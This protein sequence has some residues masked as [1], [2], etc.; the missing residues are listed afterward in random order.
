MEVVKIKID[1]LKPYA[2]NVKLHPKDQIEQIKQSIKEFGNNDP[3]AVDEDNVIIEGHG[4]YM[5]LLELGYEEVEI[6]RLCGMTEDKKNA[7]RL[8]HNKLTMN[9]GFDIDALER[10][11]ESIQMDLAKYDLEI[12]KNDE[13]IVNEIEEGEIPEAPIE[14]KTKKG[15]RFLL[16]DHELMC[17]DS[18]NAEDVAKLM[19][20]REA[21]LLLTDPPYNVS[22][23]NSEGM[24]I[25]NDDMS[26]EAFVEFIAKAM[27]NASVS[28]REGGVFYIWY[29]DIEDVAFRTACEKAGLII[30]ECLIWVKSQFVLGRQDYHWRHEP[31]LYGW[32]PGAAHYFILDRT[33]STIFEEDISKLSKEELRERL[34]AALDAMP[35][36]IFR[37][38]KP[39]KDGDHPTMKPI[40]LMA[41]MI[42]NSSE[43]GNIVLD[44]FGGSGSTMIACE[45]LGRKCLMMEYDPKYCDVIIE[46]WENLTGNKAVCLKD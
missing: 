23:S 40:K 32:K 2:N 36:T 17:G 37:E 8:V 31:C 5:A 44:L 27:E 26:H 41:R 45:Q 38:D 19:G 3:I 16:G 21:D 30:H 13:E 42:A 22:I 39:Q 6:I 24:T 33:Q 43:K 29:G 15:Q 20:G 11:L 1:K 34:K 28:I 4:R 25:E 35:S 10:E 9:S 12:E 46:R 18:T 7:Y 14:P